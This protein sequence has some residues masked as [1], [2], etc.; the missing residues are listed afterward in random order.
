VRYFR[1]FCEP[2][3]ADSDLYARHGYDDFLVACGY[4]GEV[5]KDY[6]RNY[7][8][9]RSDLFINLRE[10]SCTVANSS[11]PA[12][13]VALIDTGLGTLTGGRILRLKKLVG[14]EPFIVT[15]GDGL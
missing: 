9:H 10:G 3:I 14:S 1:S 12:W 6:F 15:Y 2:N 4:K 5:I 7:A 8:I 13:R 11:A